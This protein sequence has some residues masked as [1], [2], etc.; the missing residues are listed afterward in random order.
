MREG[1]GWSC[2]FNDVTTVHIPTGSTRT[3]EFVANEPGDWVMHCDMLHH[4][5]TQMGHDFGNVIGID[6]EGLNPAI[7]KL[8]PGY[9]VM[10]QD[11]MGDMGDMGMATARAEARGQKVE[12]CGPTLAAASD[13]AKP[14]VSG[15]IKVAMR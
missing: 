12:W 6:T 8:F 9:M 3:I 15:R 14:T 4:V 2:S 5:M 1:Y 13:E 11:G 7:K 10:G